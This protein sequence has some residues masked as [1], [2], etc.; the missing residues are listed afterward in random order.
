MLRTEFYNKFIEY[1]VFITPR[2]MNLKLTSLWSIWIGIQMVIL[3]LCQMATVEYNVM[4]H[5]CLAFIYNH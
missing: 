3:S 2:L 5:V 4:I 1:K